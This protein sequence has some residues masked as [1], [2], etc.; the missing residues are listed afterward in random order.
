MQPAKSKSAMVKNSFLFADAFI[1]LSSLYYSIL[2]LRA[3]F[4]KVR[5]A[6]IWGTFS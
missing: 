4:C 5:L 2:L 1:V 6:G 3:C